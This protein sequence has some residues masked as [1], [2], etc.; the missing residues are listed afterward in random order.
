MLA[1][2]MKRVGAN[3]MK[4]SAK[5]LYELRGLADAFAD[6]IPDALPMALLA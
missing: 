3:R 6:D 4:P 1:A 5:D 2:V